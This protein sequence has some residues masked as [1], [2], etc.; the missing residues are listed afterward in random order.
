MIPMFMRYYYLVDAL[1]IYTKLLHVAR[2]SKRTTYLAIRGTLSILT[3]ILPL[4]GG[5]FIE[6]V[7]YTFTFCVVTIVMFI[8]LFLLRGR[9]VK[10]FNIIS[11]NL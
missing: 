5:L 6:L 3:I 4:I 11:N 1:G 8:S 10:R 7:G 2:E 9:N